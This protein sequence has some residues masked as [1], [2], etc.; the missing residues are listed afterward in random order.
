MEQKIKKLL[1]EIIHPETGVDIVS[2]GFV[3]SVVATS[4]KIVVTLRFG[5]VRDPFAIKIKGRIESMLE[6]HFS[7]F[8]GTKLVM[9]KEA[10]PQKIVEPKDKTTTTHI[11]KVIAIAS[12]KGGV[13]K[14]TVT[15]NLAAT[16]RD[17]GMR[18]GVLDADI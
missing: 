11:A 14:S 18:V 13:G 6:E 4:Q 16:L 3:E 8:G 2:G 7:T 5:R 9:I 15:A 1:A 12:G 17:M 10:A